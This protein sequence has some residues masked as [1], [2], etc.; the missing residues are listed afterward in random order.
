[1]TNTYS[2]NI[3]GGYS[4]GVKG[5]ELGGVFNIDKK[6]VS[7]VQVAGVVN[8][9]GGKVHGVQLA[10]IINYVTDSVNGLQL[11]GI[12]N[13]AKGNVNGAQVA[14]YSNI[15]KDTMRGVQISIVS[16]RARRLEGV[17]IGLINIA[18][19][20]LGYSIGLVS[21]VKH[22]GIHQLS[23]SATEVTGWTAE[24]KIGNPRLNSSLLVSYNP[25]SPQKVFGYGYGIGKNIN[26]T[27]S[28][29]LYGELTE[30]Q[31]YGEV[32]EG[33]LN[34]N[35]LAA[36]GTITRINPVVTFRVGKKLQFFAGPSFSLY[37]ASSNKPADEHRLKVPDSGIWSSAWGQQTNAWVGAC[38]GITFF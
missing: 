3:I 19:T 28:W 27:R 24:Y 31:L 20:S 2:L 25:W 17:Q 14:V 15:C 38:A 18:D 37:I 10:G 23:I 30:E 7:S 11:A 13:V 5:I 12:V 26:F 29:G 36:L 22:G 35:H 4:A 34:K 33:V 8:M 1:V 9:A 16:N 21:I 6:D 32:R